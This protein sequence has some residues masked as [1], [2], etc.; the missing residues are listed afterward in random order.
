MTGDSKQRIGVT[1]MF[2]NLYKNFDLS[3]NSL[4]AAGFDGV[5]QFLFTNENSIKIDEQT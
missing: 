1:L 5:I 2:F 4:S 3:H